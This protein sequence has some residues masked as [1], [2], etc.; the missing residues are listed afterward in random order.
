MIE[1]ISNAVRTKIKKGAPR[2]AVPVTR[3]MCFAACTFRSWISRLVELDLD[4]VDSATAQKY[5]EDACCET[6]PT[7]R[8]LVALA[9]C[10]DM[11][12]GAE[13]TAPTVM[14]DIGR[15]DHPS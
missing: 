1:E 6:S 15:V 14:G 10:R 2:K 12:A 13:V 4:G 9:L 11:G 7:A 5:C 3:P 8:P